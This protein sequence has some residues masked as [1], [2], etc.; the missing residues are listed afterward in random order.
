MTERRETPGG[1]LRSALGSLLATFLLLPRRAA[2]LVIRC[3]Q[4]GISPW[5]PASCRYY[6]SCSQYAVIALRQHGLLWGIVLTVWRLLRCNPFTRGG[7]DDVPLTRPWQHAPST[8][9]GHPHEPR[10]N[11]VQL[12]AAERPG[13][14]SA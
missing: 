5:L 4:L 13:I 10:P 11:Q 7:V 2:T 9:C 14:P 1:L 6:P 8:G 12:M 3:Y